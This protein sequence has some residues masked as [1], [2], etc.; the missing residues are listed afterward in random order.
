M[1]KTFAKTFII[2]VLC[3]SFVYGYSH[4]FDVPV[5]SAS[6]DWQNVTSTSE[7]AEAFRYY[8]KSRDL[9]IDGGVADALTSFTT[10]T[11]N[12]LCSTLGIDITALQADLKKSVD[13]NGGAKFLFNQNGVALYNRIFA[14]FLQDNNLAVGDNVSNQLVKTGEW[15]D[16]G[17][18]GGC[19][20][21]VMKNNLSQ[22]VYVQ[23]RNKGTN[24][25]YFTQTGTTYKYDEDYF[26]SAFGGQSN[27]YNLSFNIRESTFEIPVNVIRYNDGLNHSYMS[28]YDNDT[29]TP[30]Q[31]LFYDVSAS[32]NLMSNGHCAVIKNDG[33]YYLGVVGKYIGSSYKDSIAL[34]CCTEILRANVNVTNVDITVTTNNETINNNTYNNNT[35]TTINHNGDVQNFDS[36]EEPP[37]GDDNT[38]SEPSVPPYYPYPDGGG[39]STGGSSTGGDGGNIDFPNFNFNFPSIDWSLGDLSNKFPFSIPF[40]LVAFYTVLNAEPVAPSIDANIPL[41]D[42]YDW[43]FQADFSQFDNYAVIIRNVEYI[44]FVVVLIF[45]TIKFVKG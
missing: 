36:E 9:T 24:T 45:L 40:D 8:C 2:I 21:Y 20:V 12:A 18:G 4:S 3:L 11:F 25:K 1:K 30:I 7:L 31:F 22:S 26:N 42:W 13:S 41:G 19:Y 43:H 34:A 17:H 35:Y 6:G 29:S 38:P 14:Q 10:Q 27:S 44:G 33:L 28:V 39:T 37:A 15:F 16:D 23:Y 32:G 5:Y